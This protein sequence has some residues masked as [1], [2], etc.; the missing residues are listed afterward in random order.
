[1]CP[2]LQQ[3]RLGVIVVCNLFTELKL[4]RNLCTHMHMT[5]Y[6][7]KSLINTCIK[8]FNRNTNCSN[9]FAR[10]LATPISKLTKLLKQTLTVR[11]FND[12]INL[13]L[14]QYTPTQALYF[15]TNKSS[16]MRTFVQPCCCSKREIINLH[17]ILNWGTIIL[18]LHQ[19]I[20]STWGLP[21][22]ISIMFSQCSPLGYPLVS[23]PTQMKRLG[24]EAMHLQLVIVH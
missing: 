7:E 11:I 10:V 20:T 3:K 16:N 23:Y 13:L 4:V 9:A 6:W 22:S 17:L 18:I 14:L 2:K 12:L 15:F 19:Y 21:G 24:Y 1:M 8:V 5:I